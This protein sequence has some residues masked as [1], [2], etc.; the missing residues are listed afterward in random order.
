MDHTEMIK[1]MAKLGREGRWDEQ[2][3]LV[4]EYDAALPRRGRPPQRPESEWEYGDALLALFAKHQLSDEVRELG[5]RLISEKQY[6]KVWD[7]LEAH[8]DRDTAFAEF[9]RTNREAY[10]RGEYYLASDLKRA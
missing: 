9:V 2:A 8:L 4:A 6:H 5:G 3:K 7:L 1:R 10:S